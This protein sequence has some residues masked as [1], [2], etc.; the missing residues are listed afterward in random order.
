MEVESRKP[1]AENLFLLLGA[2]LGNRAETM[3]QATWQ[4]S[5]KIGV[6]VKQSAIYETSA[7]G[8][9]NQPA[10]LNQVLQLE[11]TLPPEVVLAETQAIETGLGRV[12]HEH[13]GARTI[14]IDLLFYGDLVLNTDSLTLPHPFLHLRRFTLVPLAEIA[15][16]FI[17]PVLGKTIV[18]LLAACADEG[19]VRLF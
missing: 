13:W 6:I 3:A 5:V 2:N 10:F 16:D 15:P 14:D 4:L 12:R 17:H 1:K 8:L 11:T 9:T 7:W 19:E 18:E